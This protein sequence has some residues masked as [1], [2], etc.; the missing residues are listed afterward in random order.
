MRTGTRTEADYFFLAGMENFT[1]GA[2]VTAGGVAVAGVAT[3]GEA[4][5]AAMGEAGEG[6]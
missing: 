4:V 1:I 5:S 6:V 2:S 3:I